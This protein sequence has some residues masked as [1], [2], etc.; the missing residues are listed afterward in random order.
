L[1]LNLGQ[2][3]PIETKRSQIK[4]REIT[5]WGWLCQAQDQL[6]LAA[7]AKLIYFGC[8]GEELFIDAKY[9]LLIFTRL[10]DIE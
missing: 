6:G 1:P 10:G 8:A 5:S 4:S 9:T 7:E 2:T 3:E